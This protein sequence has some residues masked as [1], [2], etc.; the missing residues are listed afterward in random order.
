MMD[1][2][3]YKLNM[4]LDG[5]ES[6]ESYGYARFDWDA[7]EILIYWRKKKVI[8]DDADPKACAGPA[9]IKSGG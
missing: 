3:L 1:W 8:G 7:D 9:L 2:G 5:H 6:E 4:K